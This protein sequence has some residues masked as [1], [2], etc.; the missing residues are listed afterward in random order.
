[1]SQQLQLRH[2]TAANWASVVLAQGEVVVDETNNRILVG[3]GST[4]G[5]WPAIAPGRV[6]LI[7][8]G[9]NLDLVADTPIAVALPYGFS[10]YY[11]VAVRVLNA[12]VSLTSA[13]AAL[14]TGAGAGGIAL[15]SPQ[16]LS[17]ITATAANTAANMTPLTLAISDTSEFVSSATLYI[18]CTTAQGAPATADVAIYLDPL[19]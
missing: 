17:A 1:L 14:Y 6:A 13:A 7:A 8:R 18:R 15:A 2:D 9:V 4:A 16:A 12:S 3:D 11:L 10:R 5:G 19:S